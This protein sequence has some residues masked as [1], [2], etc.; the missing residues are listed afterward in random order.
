MP[1]NG[2]V[3][4]SVSN[5]IGGVSQQPWNVRLPSQCSESINCHATVTEF[6]RRRPATYTVANIELTNTDKNIKVC[7]IDYGNG[8]RY[9]AVFGKAGVDVFDLQG[10]KKTV[11]NS[12]SGIAYLSQLTDAQADL[13]FCTIKQYTFCVNKKVTVTASND[14]LPSTA[15]RP[16]YL[17][18]LAQASFQTKYTLVVDGYTATYETPSATYEVDG[19]PPVVSGNNILI[20]LRTALRNAMGTTVYG[21]YYTYIAGE[22][23]Y[24]RKRD[25]SDLTITTSDS[26]SDTHIKSWKDTVSH[27]E[28]LPVIAPKNHWFKVLGESSNDSDDY[29]IKFVPS[30]GQTMTEGT[31]QETVCPSEHMGLDP[32]TMPHALVRNANGTFTFK[33]ITWNQRACGDEYTNP[34]PS[35]VD[36]PIN[37]ILFYRNRL[38]MLSGDNL[39]MSEAQNFFNFFLS[40]V[41]TAVD[42]DPIDIA[43]SGTKSGALY[44]SAVYSGGLILFTEKAQY[45]VEH[46]TV[47]ANSTVSVNPVTEYESNPRVSPV[48]S[49]KTIFFANDHGKYIGIREYIALD[50]TQNTNPDAS[51]VTAHVPAYMEG[52]ICDLQ[53]ST[54]EDVLLVRTKANKRLIYV[55][56]YFWNGNE[57]MQSSWY[58]WK[59]PGDVYSAHFFDADVFMVMNYGTRW[60]IET[61][62]MEPAHKDTGEDFEFCLDRKMNESAAVIGAYDPLTKTTPLTLPYFTNT[63]TVIVIRS[64]STDTWRA[65]TVPHIV[66]RNGATISVKGEIT[67]ATK[68]YFGVPFESS[69]EFTTLGIRNQNNIAVI[70]GRLQL[71]A[72]KLNVTNTGFLEMSLKPKARRELIYTFT[73]KRLGTEYCVI[74]DV[75]IYEG[76]L[77]IPLLS[78]NDQITMIAKSS[79]VLPFS[80]VNLE[81]E[82]FYNSRSQVL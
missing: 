69:Y 61:F 43:V 12:A 15:F 49:G 38:S 45:L 28:D 76:S 41:L 50:A 39:V 80:L 1:N 25:N 77:R 48:S 67:S 40:T 81:W 21:T 8:E 3:S 9:L 10:N 14:T 19:T 54:N 46:D 35:F 6:L 52:A 42:S 26:R 27:I 13:R 55:Y 36:R 5:L 37:D 29:Y 4:G 24:I 30:S 64:G 57:K 34:L 79:N 31:W 23:L 62:S 82:G 66:S 20:K 44:G 78:R 65:G 33:A 73:G 18:F 16:Q 63:N 22:V 75:P 17:I 59:Y 72:M 53:C 51:N 47:L 32:A 68:F 71:R 11:T 60:W 2:L 58:T 74:G 7:P 70:N 56:K